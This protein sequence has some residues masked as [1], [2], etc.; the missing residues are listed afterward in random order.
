MS[1]N[2]FLNAQLSRFEQNKK[3]FEQA[4]E[5]ALSKK[6]D[7]LSLAELDKIESDVRTDQQ[8][9]MIYVGL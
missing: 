9:M 8:R 4:A 7:S 2:R 1:S 5:R 6:E 3:A